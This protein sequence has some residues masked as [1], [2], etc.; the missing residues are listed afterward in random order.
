MPKN[1]RT[2]LDELNQAFP[3]DLRT[4]NKEVD[5]VAGARRDV[6]DAGLHFCDDE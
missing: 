5:P 4:V 3:S 1:L 2:F 6:G